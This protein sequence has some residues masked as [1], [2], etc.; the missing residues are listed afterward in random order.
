M[1]VLVVLYITSVVTFLPY[2]MPQPPTGQ[3]IGNIVS[4]RVTSIG[5]MIPLGEV[6]TTK[7][8]FYLPII[9]DVSV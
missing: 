3:L 9:E 6:K 8:I 2:I 4:D 7:A 1:I 5:F